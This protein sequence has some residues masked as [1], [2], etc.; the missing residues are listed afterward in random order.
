MRGRDAV[1]DGY[2]EAVLAIAEAEGELDPTLEHLYAFAKTLEREGKL[3]QAL[4]DPGLPL[5]NKRALIHD[6]LG[7]RAN[8]NA[9]NAIALV[10]EQGRARDL[11]AIAEAAAALAAERR[12][13]VLA[14]VRSAVPLDEERRA[15]V[16][17]ALAKATGRQ[18]EIKVVV[19]PTVVGGVV[20]RV[21]D[22]V[23]DGSVRSR[24]EGAREHL[25]G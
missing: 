22:E 11:G 14:E 5:E 25:A 9:V 20:A 24:L 13:H 4:V 6:V 18:V 3:R 19:D 7:A 15:R 12:Q 17:D 21:G 23:F 1:V 10:V 16:A 2:A 8:P